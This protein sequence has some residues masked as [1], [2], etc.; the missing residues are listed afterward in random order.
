LGLSLGQWLSLLMVFAGLWWLW[1]VKKTG[2][3]LV[4]KN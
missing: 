4:R 3:P 2:H 1:Q